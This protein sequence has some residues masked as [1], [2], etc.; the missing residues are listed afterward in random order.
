MPFQEPL[1]ASI[2]Y[3]PRAFPEYGPL[4]LVLEGDAALLEQ[5]YRSGYFTFLNQSIGAGQGRKGSI[6]FA[7]MTADNLADA[8]LTIP[9]EFFTPSRQRLVE[10]AYDLWDEAMR[11][12]E[13]E[14]AR[15]DLPRQ[16][17]PR[18]QV[19]AL[20]FYNQMYDWM[21]KF[22][23]SLAGDGETLSAINRMPEFWGYF[24]QGGES[25]AFY[26]F[27]DKEKLVA[28]LEAV[29]REPIYK[30]STRASCQPVLSPTVGLL[31]GAAEDIAEAVK[32]GK[33]PLLD[34]GTAISLGL[35]LQEMQANG[36]KGNPKRFIQDQ[37]AI[38]VAQT[39]YGEIMA[40]ASAFRREMLE[41]FGWLPNAAYED[42]QNQVPRENLEQAGELRGWVDDILQEMM[43]QRV[44]A[45]A[46]IS[47]EHLLASASN[48]REGQR[49]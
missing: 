43:L 28:A 49:L 23:L 1:R 12:P 4:L 41:K 27:P 24:S 19:S 35:R 18:E 38:V 15:A 48:V 33:P 34:D 25:R 2:R 31:R 39:W 3:N 14:R 40:R 45:G 47:K 17:Y 36:W 21:G 44:G 8:L 20:V 11:M 22:N 29:E 37:V 5:V 10:A 16:V 32:K 6:L 9:P 13:E 46:A 42:Y 7:Y 26:C 30:F